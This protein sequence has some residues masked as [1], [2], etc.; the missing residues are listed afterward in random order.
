MICVG[1]SDDLSKKIMQTNHVIVINA[2]ALICF[3]LS[4]DFGRKIIE[5]KSYN[6]KKVIYF[7]F[8]HT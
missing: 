3:E 6:N 4:D 5:N 8:T 2:Q 7:S 1:L